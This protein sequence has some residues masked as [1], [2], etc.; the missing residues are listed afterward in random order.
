[1]AVRCD[2]GKLRPA[3][4]MADGRVRADA[5]ITRAGIFKYQLPGGKTRLEL[6]EQHEVFDTES[7]ASF[8]VVPVTNNHP[9]VGLLTTKNMK[10]YMVGVSGEQVIRDDDHVRTSIMVADADTIQQ[11]ES[12]KVEVSCGYTCD[13]DE[14]PG[15]HPVY[16][17]YDAKQLNIRGNHLAIVD[18]A[19][20]GRSAR[21]RMD[22]AAIQ[23]PTDDADEG[24]HGGSGMAGKADDKETVRALGAQ[25][26]TAEERA[27][28]AESL[29]SQEKLRADTESGRALQ[30]EAQI[31]ELKA[32]LAAGAAATETEAVEREKTR[33]DAAELKVARFDAALESRVRTR[34]KLERQSAVVMGDDFRMDD[35]DDRAIMAAVVKRLDAAA[36][37]A[38]SVAEGIITGRFLTLIDGFHRNARSQARVAELL[39]HTEARADAAPDHKKAYRDQWKQPLPND[40]RAGKGG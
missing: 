11:M 20:A 30:L 13:L 34:A 17:K 1:M 21:V 2:I 5:H 29:A 22:G 12:G 37:V 35:L 10:K 7:L 39:T 27:D 26:K 31:V 38:P 40:I 33:A 3:Q 8:A 14:T 24:R 16:G 4:R 19:R 18:S 9:D 23:L 15:V 36:D 6:R 28:S 25:L 32:Q